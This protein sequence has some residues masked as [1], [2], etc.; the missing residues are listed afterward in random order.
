M[1]VL[2]DEAK[3]MLREAVNGDG[4]VMYGDTLD[5]PFIQ[6]NLKSLI[7][8]KEPRTVARWKDGPEDLRLR[9]YIRDVG[10]KREIFKV[11][12]KGYELADAM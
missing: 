3:S 7:P 5:G 1:Q 10:Y 6:A 9:G 2:G 8:D 11:T 4:T 12:T